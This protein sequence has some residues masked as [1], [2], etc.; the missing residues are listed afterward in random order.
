MLCL[1]FCLALTGGCSSF[2]VRCDSH[3]RPINPRQPPASEQV[4]P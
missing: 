2:A 1:I 4:R 3:M